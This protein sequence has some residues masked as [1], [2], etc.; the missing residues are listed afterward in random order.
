MPEADPAEKQGVSNIIL[1][2]GPSGDESERRWNPVWRGA[3]GFALSVHT[4]ES[5]NVI[6]D[7]GLPGGDS[8]RQ[9][10]FSRTS[11][12]RW[13]NATRKIKP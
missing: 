11:K 9:R 8:Q 5:P 7:P 3:G 2:L 12:S 1:G 10:E 6:A 13:V 4:T